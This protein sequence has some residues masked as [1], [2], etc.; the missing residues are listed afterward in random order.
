MTEVP[1]LPAQVFVHAHLE[2]GL[3]PVG[4]IE[5]T[6]KAWP[7]VQRGL[8]F[9]YGR[10][11]LDGVDAKPFEIDPINIP[12][13]TG[14][15]PA[16]EGTEI[17]GVFR[18]AGPDGWGQELIRKRW[19]GRDVG[20]L[21]ILLHGSGERTGLLSFST[22]VSGKRAHDDL[23]P[24]PISLAELLELSAAVQHDQA[25]VPEI[26][27]L[28]GHGSSLGGARPKAGFVHD[29][30]L[31]VA[32]FPHRDDAFD[33]QKVEAACLDMAETIGID[34]PS[35]Q[36]V[37]VTTA[38]GRQSVLLVERFDRRRRGN[39]EERLAYLSAETALGKT[40]G[41][42]TS[43]LRYG[44]LAAIANRLGHAA[45]GKDGSGAEIFK[46]L[47]LNVAVHNTDDHLRNHAFI[48]IDGK[49]RLSPVFD[50]VP[51]AAGE[52]QMTLGLV[53][54]RVP[55][56]AEAIDAGQTLALNSDESTVIAVKCLHVLA[57]WRE[58]M[59]KRAVGPR[60]MEVLAP[61]F[62][63]IDMWSGDE[64]AGSKPT[65]KSSTFE[66]GS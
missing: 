8:R 2:G 63:T 5:R 15:I 34:T 35:R 38:R 23:D 43:S 66:I 39:R 20:M 22:D 40:G 48:R 29:S 32:K 37:E 59:A 27:R 25:A 16:P 46:R 42:Y 9:R 18:D 50:V 19:V 10:R 58:F 11:W 55:S 54:S 31:W 28:L 56:I 36:V 47:L 51:Q 62:A 45:A 12:F 1:E 65:R 57:R 49:W 26:S 52:G 21:E 64:G 24:A 4:I 44:D 14:W 17:H 61:R 33:V 13:G 7:P 3:A 6:G 53:R 60:D 41:L 30:R